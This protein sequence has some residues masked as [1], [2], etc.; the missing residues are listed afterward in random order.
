M[1]GLSTEAQT[2]AIK[3]AVEIFEEAKKK[4]VELLKGR[5][6][7]ANMWRD[8]GIQIQIACNH[9]QP[10]LA[11]YDNH[12]ALFGSM[13][14][15][16]ARACTQIAKNFPK[17]IE[18]ADIQR[19]EQIG[20]SAILNVEQPKRLEQ[21]TAHTRNQFNEFITGLLGVNSR[22]KK[23]PAIDRESAKQIVQ[24]LKPVIDLYEKAKALAE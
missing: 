4:G 22:I 14:F 9:E 17:K 12:K 23:L 2:A 7:A 19:A 8:A 24:T 5:T 20:M 21:Q 13:S 1:L 15:E 11:F 10:T 18:V 16:Q 3:Y 6:E